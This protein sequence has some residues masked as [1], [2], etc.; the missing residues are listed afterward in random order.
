MKNTEK[1]DLKFQ[2]LLK[3]VR[4]ELH[5]RMGTKMC[6]ELHADCCDCK[7]RFLIGLINYWIDL[8]EPWRPKKK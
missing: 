4:I 8:L 7:T 3:Q 1:K 6:K 2:K 5:K